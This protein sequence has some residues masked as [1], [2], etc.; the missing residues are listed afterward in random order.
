MHQQHDWTIQK[1]LDFTFFY[2]VDDALGQLSILTTTVFWQHASRPPPHLVRVIGSLDSLDQ[3]WD[4]THNFSSQAQNTALLSLLR[5]T[6]SM[7]QKRSSVM[8]SLFKI[9]EHKI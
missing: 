5:Q 3:A 9:C 6:K 1:H 4:L 8:M 7:E 2:V